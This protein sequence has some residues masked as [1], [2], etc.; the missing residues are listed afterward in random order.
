VALG[1]ELAYLLRRAIPDALDPIVRRAVGTVV[2][3]LGDDDRYRIVHAGHFSSRVAADLLAFGRNQRYDGALV[4]IDEDVARAVLFKG[5]RI[6]G[7]SSDFLF[8]RIARILRRGDLVDDEA[9]RRLQEMEEA[10]G[11]ADAIS[12]LQPAVAAWAVETQVWEVVAALFLVRAG[13]FLFVEGEP[14]LG[15]VP[16]TDLNP[17]D[18]A[19]E[20]LRRYD[21]WRHGT[22]QVPTPV[23]E[24]PA[25]RPPRSPS[26]AA[27]SETGREDDVERVLAQLRALGEAI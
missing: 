13:H 17:M 6:V 3:R 4:V 21:E 22:T 1:D 10:G 26:R 16:E 24:V 7:A 27:A 9:M 11:T 23:R 25:A 15:R 14:D 18:L 8:E 12:H 20:G 2:P 19:I 5:G